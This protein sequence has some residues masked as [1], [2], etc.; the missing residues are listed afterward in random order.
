MPVFKTFM[1]VMRKRIKTSMIYITIFVAICF[2]MTLSSDADDSFS[3]YTLSV[4]I[5]DLDNTEAS[6]AIADYIAD[7][8]EIVSVENN[9]DAILDSLY[10]L[11]ADIV[12]TI[13]EGYSQR[14]AN[15]QT[16]NLFSDYRVPGSY[17]AELFDSQI[18]RYISI[19]SSYIAAGYSLDE[20]VEK[21][22]Q[23]VS[24]KVDV[25]SKNFSEKS[26]NAD[27]SMFFQY[28]AYILII[29]LISAICPVLL[30]MTSK[31]IKNR[32][33][34]SCI[35]V[36]K[37]MLQLALGTV[38]VSLGIFA[39]LIIVAAFIYGGDLFS[40]TGLLAILN[41]FVFLVFVIML[42][43][44]IAVAAPSA[45][46]VDMIANV[47]S[48]G[49]SFLCGVF[50][51]QYLLSDSVLKVGR[52]FPA[53]WYIRAN[54]MLAGAEG[55]IYSAGEYAKCLFVQLGISVVVFIA[56]LIIARRKRSTQSVN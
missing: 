43:L 28:L 45:R 50:V 19:I 21:T 54:N 35:S 6:K 23:T 49:M 2:V 52:F 17:T 9:K 44:L 33:N 34:C 16:D 13:N 48:L 22:S 1:K 11:E 18:N 30:A 15:G 24:C 40:S 14:I 56:A 3:D 27:F 12:L 7:N 37:Q 42:T 55:A 8:H 41:A 46:A 29:A 4:S 25:E 51:P 32:T 47:F 26:S 10:Y 20:A 39:L 38:V 31:E 36:S 5:N 53:Y